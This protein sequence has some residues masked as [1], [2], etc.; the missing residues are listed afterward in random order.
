[1]N[2]IRN[3]ARLG[4]LLYLIVAV[5]GGFSELYIRS[6]IRVPGDAAA[7]AANI[8]SHSALFR[9]SFVSDLIAFTSFLGVGIVMYAIFRQVSPIAAVAML[10]LNAV[11]VAISALNMLNQLGALLVATDPGYTAGLSSEASQALALLLVDLHQQGYLISQIFFGLYLAPL[12]YAVYRSGYVPK[13]LGL[14]LAAGATGYLGDVAIT[15]LSPGFQS[16]TGADLGMV[17]GIAEV[18]FLAW[19]LIV[20]VKSPANDRAEVSAPRARRTA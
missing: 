9:I 8:A 1:V 16:G 6:S 2:S 12:G 5:S 13:V 10:V 4:G 7:T 20:G 3:L 17:G 14:V 19:L 11:S 18:I 15:Y